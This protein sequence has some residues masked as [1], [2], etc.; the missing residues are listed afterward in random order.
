MTTSS[1]HFL[2]KPDVVL[3]GCTFSVQRDFY[4]NI[5]T[6]VCFRNSG[7]RHRGR[8]QCALVPPEVEHYWGSRRYDAYE[9]VIVFL[10]DDSSSY[11]HNSSLEG[12]QRVLVPYLPLT[13][14]KLNGSE[15]SPKYLYDCHRG[16]IPRKPIVRCVRS[17]VLYDES[18]G[19]WEPGPTILDVS[20][21]RCLVSLKDDRLIFIGGWKKMLI[22]L[23]MEN[24][25]YKKF[26]L[27]GF[28]QTCARLKNG[29]V[30][31]LGGKPKGKK[32]CGSMEFGVWFLEC[33]R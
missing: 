20:Y 31:T 11:Y 3:S 2:I 29:G 17:G 6:G 28:S 21:G 22:S 4:P 16:S 26:K 32:S 27:F 14:L 19:A 7:I 30:M 15:T 8:N 12:C 25:L 10:D 33:R 24:G 23:K 5:C 9:I 13:E 18:K 1:V